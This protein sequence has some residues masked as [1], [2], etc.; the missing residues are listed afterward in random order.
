MTYVTENIS[1]SNI[2]PLV[3]SFKSV[4]QTIYLEKSLC[5]A[6]KKTAGVHET[7]ELFHHWWD[8]PPYHSSINVVGLL[9]T[10]I[11]HLFLPIFK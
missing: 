11:Q 5:D 8:F 9:V 7:L 6:R 10:H 1:R 2:P 3:Y 4:Q